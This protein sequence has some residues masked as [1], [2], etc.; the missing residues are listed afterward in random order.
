M[1]DPSKKG[2]EHYLENKRWVVIF[3]CSSKTINLAG[4]KLS[5]DAAIAE[6]DTSLPNEAPTITLSGVI[7]SCQSVKIYPVTY[8]GGDS[9]HMSTKKGSLWLTQGGSSGNKSD[10]GENKDELIHQ[11]FWH[12]AP[13]NEVYNFSASLL[14]D[15]G[16][17]QT[18]K[19]GTD[20]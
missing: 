20:A 6:G 17:E 13:Y 16:G 8:T 3:N 9:F 12:D 19:N 4:W 5:Y 10:A 11:V 2:R 18:C 7:E 1:I 14:H 15:G